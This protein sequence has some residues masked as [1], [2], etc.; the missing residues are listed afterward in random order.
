M[1]KLRRLYY[2]LFPT[3]KRL[4]LKFCSY[5]EADELIKSNDARSFPFKWYLAKEEDT[6]HVIG[7]VYIERKERIWE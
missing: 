5:A 4:E 1:K 3:Y 2:R 6:N 7:M